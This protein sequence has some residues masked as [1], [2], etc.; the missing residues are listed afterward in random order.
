M[1]DKIKM[2][3]P[4]QRQLVKSLHYLFEN[5]SASSKVVNFSFK[6]NKKWGS[7]DRKSFA[8][9][10]YTIVR[11]AGVYF[12]EIGKNDFICPSE[13]EVSKIIELYLEG[14][15]KTPSPE[16]MK[17][18]VS[19]DLV[20]LVDLEMTEEEKSD[21]LKAS[22]QTAPVYLRVNLNLISDEECLSELKEE[23]LKVELVKPGC[24]ELLERKN[25]FLAPSFKK[26]HFEVQDGA[27]QDVAYFMELERG[28]R[29]ADSCAGAG[30]KTLHMSSLL[31]NTGTIVAMDVFPRRLE[32]LKKRMRRSKSQNIEIKAIEGTKTIKRMAGKFDRLLLDVP[33]TGSGTYRRKPESKLF[34]T[35]EEHSRLLK[36]QEEVLEQ[37]SKLVKLGGKMVYATCSVFPSENMKQV[38]AFLK[39][40]DE[41]KLESS[42]LN[43]VGQNGFDGFFM[44]RLIRV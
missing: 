6:N 24:L 28:M 30:G 11:D 15:D 13:E 29:V 20:D 8:E 10:F 3:P 26:G 12:D 43:K 35:K 14:F 33:C 22:S 37:H 42:S 36:I 17:H 44:A 19:K 4:I 41:F 23:G 32:E 40:H 27:S 31:G 7:R 9:A 5:K 1:A 25:V 38:E 21:F 18:S 2:F 39:R 34:F 16:L